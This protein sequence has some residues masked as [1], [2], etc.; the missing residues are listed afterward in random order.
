MCNVP[1]SSSASEL[2]VCISG[3]VQLSAILKKHYSYWTLT[4]DWSKL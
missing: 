3:F 1:V 4:Q 2:L